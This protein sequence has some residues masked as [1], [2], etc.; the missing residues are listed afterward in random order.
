MRKTLSQFMAHASQYVAER[1]REKK[2]QLV[3][4]IVVVVV[5]RIVFHFVSSVYCCKRR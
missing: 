3:Y 2:M 1:D 4:I 5:A